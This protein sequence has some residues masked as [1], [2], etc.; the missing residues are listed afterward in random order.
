MVEMSDRSSDEFEFLPPAREAYA[1]DEAC[2][3][4]KMGNHHLCG[5]ETCGCAWPRTAT[6][7]KKFPP[8]PS[9]A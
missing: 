6:E 3:V 1:C 7:A 2:A 4:C 9:Y 8:M 5:A